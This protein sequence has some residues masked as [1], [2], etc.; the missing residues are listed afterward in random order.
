[1][2][3]IREKAQ[4]LYPQI[5]GNLVIDW[6][7]ADHVRVVASAVASFQDFSFLRSSKTDLYQLVFYNFANRFQQQEQGQFL[8]PLPVIEFLVQLVNPRGEDKLIDPCCGIGDF[9]SLSYVHSLE[10][11]L[12]WQLDDSNIFG[13]DVSPDMITLASLNMLLNGD[14]NARLFR[15]PDKGSIS[16]KVAAQHPPGIVELIP[17]IHRNLTWDEWPDQTQL[18]KFDVVLT[19]PPFG[20]DRA[21]RPQSDHDR[22]VIEMYETWSLS[23]ADTIDLGVIFLENAIRVLAPNGRLGIV[24][25]NSIAS[26]DRWRL[27][28]EWFAERMRIVALFDLPAN[29][30]AETGVN[31]TL[32]VA[33]KPSER[34]LKQLNHDGYSVF[35]RDI[36]EV[37]YTRRTSK[38]NVFFQPKYKL[39]RET[40]D[41]ALTD[42]GQL[43]RE[44][45]FTSTLADFRA[46]AAGQ[47]ET[48]QKIFI[49]EN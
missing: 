35:A 38:R 22:E 18:M 33:Y 40:F 36:H 41:V 44:E 5:L 32:L 30:F 2:Q 16:W 1:M 27:A 28:R 14:G 4:D 3:A 12:P 24:L 19:N 17:G 48:L 49:A 26:T 37:G 10:K 13:V 9:L 15:A 45:Q 25:S 47:E 21:Y 7:E 11:D 23:T 31:T 8:T 46:W 43:I 34:A 42:E 29:V 39:D 6:R 20:E